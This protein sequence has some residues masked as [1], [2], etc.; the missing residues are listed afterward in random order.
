MALVHQC[1][2]EFLRQ[3]KLAERRNCLFG[4]ISGDSICMPSQR[5]AYH[6]SQRRA[7]LETFPRSQRA[8]L[9]WMRSPAARLVDCSTPRSLKGASMGGPVMAWN[10]AGPRTMYFMNGLQ[11][12]SQYFS[13]CLRAA[14]GGPTYFI[15][16]LWYLPNF[17][18]G[19]GL[20]GRSGANLLH[21]RIMLAYA[22]FLGVARGGRMGANLLPEW[23][24][25]IS[26]IFLDLV[27]GGL[28]GA[29][30]LHQWVAVS[31]IVSW[32]GEGRPEEA[33]HD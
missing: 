2:K 15:S 32:C 21:E 7:I 33:G 8:R 13:V 28:E 3:A 20:G 1:T 27:G 25:V 14:G 16:G 12:F 31:S 29:N 4:E 11:S 9:R 17:F 19:V 24:A 23:V 6:P 30:R 18:F 5:E 26:S 22:V 10:A